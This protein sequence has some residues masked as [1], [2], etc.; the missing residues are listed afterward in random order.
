M[1][2]RDWKVQVTVTNLTR[3]LKFKFAMGQSSVE[4]GKELVT[5]R[6]SLQD[7]LSL[8]LCDSKTIQSLGGI[9]TLQFD[10]EL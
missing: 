5:R 3:N 8:R 2:T 9:Y 10:L 7:G 1:V 4:L 6:H